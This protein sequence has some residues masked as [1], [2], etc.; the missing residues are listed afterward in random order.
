MRFM[1]IYLCLRIAIICG[2]HRHV[3]RIAT[4]WGGE[5]GPVN[6]FYRAAYEIQPYLYKRGYHRCP[7]C[8]WANGIAQRALE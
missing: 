1:F 3:Y 2:F 5:I 7:F 4:S 6:V 8:H